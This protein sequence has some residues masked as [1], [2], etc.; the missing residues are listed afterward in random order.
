MF[1]STHRRRETKKSHCSF[2]EFRSISPEAAADFVANALRDSGPGQ[3]PPL[4]YCAQCLYG[5][6]HVVYPIDT[7]EAASDFH[8]PDVPDDDA[9]DL[10]PPVRMQK[11][12]RKQ[13]HAF[14]S[15]VTR[16]L[17]VVR[18]E[19]QEAH[20]LFDVIEFKCLRGTPPNPNPHIRHFHYIAQVLFPQFKERP[21][22]FMAV[23]IHKMVSTL[24]DCLAMCNTVKVAK[25]SQNKRWP[26]STKDI[27][28]NGGKVTTKA[29]L[30]WSH[31]SDDMAFTA[32]G[33]LGNMV[34]ICGSLIID[35]IA[36]NADSG[37]DFV[38]TGFRMCRDATTAL[39]HRDNDHSEY[40]ER[41]SLAAEFYQRATFAAV[42]LESATTF[43]PEIFQVL[44]AGRER[45]MV[46]LLSLILELRDAPTV[47]LDPDL[48]RQFE[49]FDWTIFSKLARQILADHPELQLGKLHEDIVLTQRAIEDPLFT[50][51]Q[52]LIAA[53]SRARCH[54][55]GCPQS[56]ASTG[57]EFKRCAACRVVAYC[58][59]ACQTRAWKTGPHAHKHICAKIKTL[60]AQG[61]GLD[62]RD[63]FVRNCREAKVSAD[64]ALAVA[65]WN[66]DPGMT[67]S[68][69]E[70]SVPNT[71][72][73]D[74][75]DEMFYQLNPSQHPQY[76]E[77][78]AKITA[79]WDKRMAEAEPA[80]HTESR[81]SI[82]RTPKTE[83]T[84]KK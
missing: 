60:I 64:E 57:T 32:F 35:D 62:D 46:Q 14:W 74:G 29:F 65:K 37:E 81:H 47:W 72:G 59:K 13:F 54:A 83:Q 43:A 84:N 12:Q 73:A 69:S 10:K 11:L 68:Q 1:P 45:K 7:V 75:F 18:D 36:A 71:D 8:R 55:P 76:P 44:V 52:V 42:F 61:G 80:P 38:S 31:Y 79:Y 3:E 41:Q 49:F 15:A 40:H 5:A 17:T 24:N 78:W 34:K 82:R 16:F 70:G 48:E 26:T 6:M 21:E 28:P 4:R 53:K 25:N 66:F 50:A 19:I 67:I 2:S 63:A 27:M 33:I 20:F 30:R 23:C 9:A 77:R 22:Q 58:G 51:H 39:C 56:L